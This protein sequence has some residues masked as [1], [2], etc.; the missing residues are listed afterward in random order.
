M[1]SSPWTHFTYI[2]ALLFRVTCQCVRTKKTGSVCK[3]NQYASPERTSRTEPLWTGLWERREK[4]AGKEKKEEKKVT[5]RP[6]NLYE[7]VIFVPGAMLIFSV[8]F[9]FYVCPAQ[10]PDGSTSRIGRGRCARCI[11]HCESCERGR[12]T[13]TPSAAASP[14]CLIVI[15]FSYALQCQP[16]AAPGVARS[17]PAS[18]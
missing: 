16:P 15:L 2:Y 6:S 12:A 17:L 1:C 18:G 10:R 13:H 7:R 14:F 4:K 3:K 9:R 8:W 5:R 11:L